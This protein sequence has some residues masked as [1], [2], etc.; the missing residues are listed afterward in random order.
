MGHPRKAEAGGEE[1][2]H[3]SFKLWK[4]TMHMYPNI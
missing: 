1:Y 3:G 4:V 2:F